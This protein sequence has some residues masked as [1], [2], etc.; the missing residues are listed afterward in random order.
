M[1]DYEAEIER[2]LDGPPGRLA[3][4]A[5]C[6]VLGRAGSPGPLVERCERRLAAW[7]DEVREAPWSWLAAWHAGHSRPG[8]RLARSIAP[9]S[10]HYSTIDPPFPDPRAQPE[11]RGISGLDL[12][13]FAADQLAAVVRDLAHWESLRSLR[14]G[15]LTEMDGELVAGFAAAPGLARFEA[16]NLIDIR[17]DMWHF[18]KPPF[19]PPAGRPLRLRHAGLRAPD[20]VYL[21]RSGLVPELRSA[22]V[23]VCSAA[24]AR[25]LAACPELAGLGRLAL[26]FRCGRN[27]RQPLWE[28]FFGNVI[29]ED[30]EAAETFFGQAD[31][32]GLKALTLQ[33]TPMGLG[34]EGLG[35]RGVAATA[36]LLP[37]LTEL[38]LT[39]LPLGDGPL[40]RVLGALDPG[41]LEKLALVD[42]VAT[43]V[44]AAAFAGSFPRLRRLDL[45][46][47]QLTEA[48]ARHL[49]AE[50]R[51]PALEHLDLSGWT[52]S[53]YYS[54]PAVQPIGDD[55]VRAWAGSATAAGL[56]SL[57]LSATGL[58]TEGLLTLLRS[59][60]LE[61]LTE[62]N[63]SGN[64]LAGWP[65]DVPLPPA[66]RTVDLSDCGLDDDAIRALT[67]SGPMPAL[68][69]ISLAYNT[70]GTAGAR[71]LAAWGALPGLWQLNLYDNVIGDDGLIALATSQAAQLLVELDLQQDCWNSARRPLADPL[72]AE[73]AD[74]ASFPNLDAMFLGVVDEY[75]GARYSSGFPPHVRE[76]L[77]AA[78]TTR[79]ELVAFLTHLEL[80]EQETGTGGDRDFR[81]GAAGKHREHVAEAR[82]FA[83][84]MREGA[85]G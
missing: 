29:A 13:S 18:E 53:P 12:G 69:A 54:R 46:R 63:L 47:N 49:A 8:W 82:E 72:P 28:P 19:R 85:P 70:I 75:H 4:R 1:I 42:V 64:R 51:F 21:L 36:G 6:G 20:L 67:S 16:L 14:I 83:R 23:L 74:A 56:K 7:P 76:Q 68:T 45:S 55:G 62:L 39:E 77:A 10:L 15:F 80:S 38:T 35:A 48:G 34:R 31:L 44:T 22:D 60:R 79:P 71:A 59:A 50:V 40:P 24:E 2:I 9:K 11:F 25:D 41:R 17:E 65:A 5:L 37:R 57:N 30:D 81:P 27:G 84:R 26:G 66:V 3:F 33:G 32:S 43:D 52:S 78:E 61:R 73:V 58:G